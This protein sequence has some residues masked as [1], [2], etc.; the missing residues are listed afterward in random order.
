M[1][2]YDCQKDLLLACDASP[3]GVGAVLSHRMEDGSERP[4]AFASRSLS[5]AEKNYAQLDKE[6]LAIVFGVKKFH[7]YLL[8]RH[9]TI[10]SDHK[11]LQHLFGKLKAV[12]PMAS[13]RIQHWALTLAAYHYDISYK[14]GKANANADVLSRLPLPG[15]A[16]EVPVPEEIVL[17]LEG[18]QTSP[19]SAN[20]I[21][22]WTNNDPTLARV[23]KLV[24]Q[25]WVDTKDPL[26]QPYQHRKDELSVQ[27]GCLLW[28]CRV[29]VPP[30]GRGKVLEELHTAHPGISRMKSLARSYIWWPNLDVDIEAKVKDCLQCQ[31]NQ[32]SPPTVPMLPWEWPSKPWTR[33]HIDHAGPFMGKMFLVIVDSHS[34]WLEVRIVPSVT[35][36]STIQEL[37]S[38]F[39]THGLPE[40]IVSDNGTAFTSSEFQEFTS[41]NGIRHIKTAPY[42]PALNGLAERAVQTFKEGLKKLTEGSVETKLS[43]FLFQYRLTPHSITGKSPAELL[44]GRQL[45]AHLDQLTPNLQAQVQQ[46]QQKQKDYHDQT[47]RSRTFDIGD[48]VFIRNFTKGPTWLPGTV[49]QKQGPRTFTI[50]LMDGRIW[51][52]HVNHI[53]YR[54]V[55]ITAATESEDFDDCIPM[56]AFDSKTPVSENSSTSQILPRC[57][58]RPRHPPDRLVYKS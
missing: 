44:M 4:I 8:G 25:G 58:T 23:K 47:S 49:L 15:H 42:H 18:L 56:M 12:P 17:L 20:H 46:K 32:K 6:G 45:R 39:A 27:D 3:Y 43:R 29:I 36:L 51:R 13:A 19:V 24:L 50:K 9:F 33:L 2:H 7:H 1:A 26:I 21:K 30:Q 55:D 34:K 57:S 52:R 48:S 16:G 5:P 10:Q 54:S 41:K 31:E 38:V 53:R 40:I 14:P 22:T 11:P 37:R 28:G 35:S